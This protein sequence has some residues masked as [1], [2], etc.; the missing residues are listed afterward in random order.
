MSIIEIEDVLEL[1]KG[2]EVLKKQFDN[3]CDWCWGHGFGKC[4]T[5]KKIFHKYYI[6]IR[7]KE[8]QVKLGLTK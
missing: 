6:P 4:T 1:N 5:C 3:Y 2:S 8:L 7:K